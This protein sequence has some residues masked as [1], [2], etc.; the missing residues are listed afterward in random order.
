MAGQPCV[1]HPNEITF[2]RCG[3]CESPIC[4]RCMVDTPVGKKCRACA[5][6][7]SHLTESTTRE[8][9]LAF[10]AATAVAIPA[11]WVMQMV[12]L[13]ILPAVVY[14][15]LIAEV[16]LRAGKR[17]RSVAMQIATGV[18]AFIGGMLG[19]HRLWM[20]LPLL[21]RGGGDEMP[22]LLAVESMLAFPL[23]S[24]LIGVGIAVSRV[25]SL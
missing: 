23:L 5:R 1:N 22:P 16:A 20:L 4:V 24:T 14:G 15:G 9:A 25:R 3:R 13:M 12:P 10:V 21:F 6:N 18:A 7:R 19:S 17:R 8:V 11:G 2:V